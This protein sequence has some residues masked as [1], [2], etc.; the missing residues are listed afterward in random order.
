[1]IGDPEPVPKV[2]LY[3][4]VYRHTTLLN[5]RLCLANKGY[6][7]IIMLLFIFLIVQMESHGLHL[8]PNFSDTKGFSGIR[9]LSSGVMQIIYA[10]WPTRL[11][12]LSV[13]IFYILKRQNS[14]RHQPHRLG[15]SMHSEIARTIHIELCDTVPHH[16][17]RW[18]QCQIHPQS[19]L[20]VQWWC[21]ATGSI[22]RY[23]LF[24][25]RRTQGE[26]Y[27]FNIEMRCQSVNE[28]DSS[29]K[30]PDVEKMM[31]DDACSGRRTVHG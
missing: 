13:S 19:Q 3:F 9:P 6:Y 23:A 31:M 15:I 18:S 8:L 26:T 14:M 2:K 12:S 20:Q 28:K 11:T 4:C 5:V 10:Q 25:K 30:W 7:Y 1:M 24:F 21:S 16:R 22:H 29:E 17:R 27:F